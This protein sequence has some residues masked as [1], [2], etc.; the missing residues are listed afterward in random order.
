MQPTRTLTSK[1]WR[2][3][4]LSV[5]VLVLSACRGAGPVCAPPA[6][7]IADAGPADALAREPAGGPAAGE[8]APPCAACGPPMPWSPPAIAGPW[9]PDEY[10][11]D[12]GDRIPPAAVAH[13][14]EVRGLETEDTIVHFDTPD[15]LTKV[16]ASNRVCIYAPRFG[17][18]RQVTGVSK[19]D[20]VDHLG[21]LH[22]P[23]EAGSDKDVRPPSADVLPQQ[24]VAALTADQLALLRA[25]DVQTIASQNVPATEAAKGFKA[26]EDFLL[27]RYGVLDN[28]EKARMVEWI[29]AAVAWTEVTGLE[30]AVEGHTAQVETGDRR[31]QATYTVDTPNLSRLRV[32]KVA[33]K[34]EARPGDIIDFTIRFDNIGATPVGNVT[35]VDNLTTRLELVPNSQEST[36]NARFVAEHNAAGSLVLRWEIADPLPPG[37]GGLVRFKCKVR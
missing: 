7:E 12:G 33:S 4:V 3:I 8:T 22:R 25:A 16:E 14:W 26:H 32:C 36:L 18:V 5:C 6:A 15:G 17:A 21:H 27:M 29:D 35:V 11:C 34:H 31:A 9:P 28:S 19:Y 2:T 30:I 1:L 10:L 24:P 20:Q 13:D 37:Q 23:I